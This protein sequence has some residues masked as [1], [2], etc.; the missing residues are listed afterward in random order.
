VFGDTF[1]QY[2]AQLPWSAPLNSGRDPFFYSLYIGTV[3][4]LL[5]IM[6]TLV[7]RRRW[8]FFWL[9]T[10]IIGVLLAFGDYTPAYPVLQ[11]IVPP[12]RSFRFPAKF[13]VFMS[14]AVAAL[15]ASAADALQAGG[16]RVTD[17]RTARAVRATYGA[18]LAIVLALVVLISLV[19]VAPFTGARAFYDLG[20]SVG[21]GDPVAGAEYLFRT[22]PPIATR[23]L[24]VL[25]TSVLLVYLAARNAH[26]PRA[27]LL[28]IGLA[29]A[30]LLA[31]SAGLNPVLPASRLG[32]PAWIAAMAPHPAERFYFGGKFRGSLSEEDIDL[33]G[34][35]WRP[36]QNVTVEEGRTLMMAAVTM[37]PAAW[38]VRELVSYD[39]PLLWP[40]EHA[41][42]VTLFERADRAARMRFL[43]RGG[44]RYCLLPSPPHPGAAPLARVGEQFGMMAVY[45]CV[46]GARRAY[47]VPAA[48]MVPEITTQLDRLFDE[49]FA[50]DSTVMLEQP[51]PEPAGSPGAASEASA[52]IT[53]DADSDVVVAAVAGAGGG[54]LVLL[55]SFDRAW[56]AEVDGEPAPM[57]R[58][59]ALYRAVRLSPGSHTVAFK[60]RPTALYLCALF[61]LIT[62]VALAAIAAARGK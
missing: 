61:S 45:E 26:D 60:Y 44:V 30:E 32:P 17:A 53:T 8:R 16:A 52:R 59:N 36:P 2:N 34:I 20:V 19:L 6:G 3:A 1:Y 27:R 28:L 21:V 4:L 13:L 58:A 57:L 48:A 46:P 39:L 24:I 50:A 10:G 42:A 18:G 25:A 31:A 41:R 47:V 9:A 55:D 62:A 12:V 15:A 7:G 38:G 23:I 29:A 14:F 5:S 35:D 51:L 49:S 54:Y 37:T 56:R 33:R 43:A 40:V 22:V 11:R